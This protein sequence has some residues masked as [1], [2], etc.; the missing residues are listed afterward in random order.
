MNGLSLLVLAV[1]F[2]AS[3]SPAAAQRVVSYDTLSGDTPVAVS[4]G[5]CGGEKLG[6]IFRDLP[7]PARGLDPGDFPLVVDALQIAVASARV[8]GSAGAY[9]CGG[10]VTGGTA[11]VDVEVWA[12]I[13]PPAGSI[14]A[15][16]AEGAWPEEVP[17]W[18]AVDVP[19]TMSVADMEGSMNYEV[20]F[21]RLVLENE[22]A[23]PVRVPAPA[24]Y[25][26]VVVAL[27]AGMDTSASCMDMALDPPSTLPV[28]DD[29][30]RIANERGLVYAIGA[31][32]L[33][34]EE[35]MV[36]GD[37][38]VRVEITSEGTAGPDAGPAG[39][40]AGATDAGRRTD[41]AANRDSGGG[42]SSGG[43]CGCRVARPGSDSPTLTGW[44][45]VGA[46]AISRRRR[47]RAIRHPRRPGR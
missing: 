45:A 47:R 19:L 40:D 46:V 31:G 13:T 33:W 39:P 20:M 7:A 8:T 15:L 34:N 3:S 37:W 17:V 5:F 44:L 28:R 12:G 21:N 26:R 42:G 9:M 29:D 41:G 27:Q 30:G 14:R 2:L 16:P 43:G 23:M 24:T 10:S 11:L 32:W 38:G 6:V 22:M 1:V 18:A 36:R 35:A 4:C 25:L